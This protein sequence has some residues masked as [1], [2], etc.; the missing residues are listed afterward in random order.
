MK[1]IIS[2]VLGTY[3]RFNFLKLFLDSLRKEMGSFPY[4]TIIIDGGSTDGTLLW[5]IEQKDIILILQHNHGE[6]NGKKI[7]RK[8]WGYFMNLGFKCA[9]GKYI[10]ML[11]DD[12]LIVP[13]S[14]INGYNLFEQK[15]KEGVNV[16]AIAFYWRD[17]PDTPIESFFEHSQ[18]ST[19]YKIGQV[20]G[21]KMFVNHGMYLRK[22][23]EDVG[24][25][26]EENY[27]F[28]YA[29]VDLSLKI[30]QKGYIIIDSPNSY[31]E[32]FSHANLTARKSN[33][34][35]IKKDSDSFHKWEQIYGNSAGD[36]IEK[37]FNDPY[38]VYEKFPKVS[39]IYKTYKFKKKIKPFLKE[40]IKKIIPKKYYKKLKL[41]FFSSK[42]NK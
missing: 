24:Y 1:P 31:I 21:N 19:K 5:L 9:Q 18:S 26:D 29:D 20:Y 27:F 11:S 30:W 36:L 32:H 7:E 13:G 28:Y 23:I 25:I 34:E 33:L 22:A 38:R 35:Q 39:I 3:N 14:I 41:L 2:I 10:C 37:E 16:G 15:L 4:E 17:Y 40:L 42:F 12:C 8:P 6:W